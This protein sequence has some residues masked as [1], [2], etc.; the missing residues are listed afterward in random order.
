[1]RVKT[2]F[3]LV[4]I[5]LILLVAIVL[6]LTVKFDMGY[7]LIAVEVLSV[8]I[9]IL[10][11]LLYQRTIRPLQI[12][13][14][15]MDLVKSQDFN[16]RLQQVKQHDADKVVNLFNKILGELKDERLQLREKNQIL[17][18]LIESSPMGVIMLDLDNKISIINPA[19][20]QIM[21]C[22]DIISY[23][24]KSISELD[25]VMSDE[26]STMAAHSTKTVNLNDA[27]IYK[28]TNECFIVDG[29]THTFYL[30]E[31]MTDELLLAQQKTYN[32]V[33]R[34]IAH[35]VNNSMAGVVSTLDMV[36]SDIYNSENSEIAKLLSV[37]SDR[38]KNLSLFIT[39]FANVVK[40]PEPTLADLSLD[41]FITDNSRLFE[42]Q[43]AGFDIKFKFNLNSDNRKVK[44]DPILM[45]QVIINII[46]NG[47]E[48]IAS[49]GVIELSTT[50][51]PHQLIISNNGASI[52]SV[53]Q[54]NIFS[55]FF[56]TKP[57]GQG[58]GLLVVRDILSKHNF[59]FSLKTDSD[60]ITRFTIQF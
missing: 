17:D 46:K 9:I 47:I 56:T 20:I 49:D 48:A 35:E 59:K 15:G 37:S 29:Y 52:D 16:S 2:V 10:L 33:I 54:R 34:M 19:A 38:C 41:G 57:N 7:Y 13:I 58:I 31:K 40:I 55:P 30:I 11:V 25:C 50:L 14:K 39:K 22:E 3:F 6:E 5:V 45:E 42:S 24:G 4:V 44:I 53:T 23:I 1:M 27:N 28:C 36:E 8:V 43:V 26:L 60:G 12:I 18:I 51:Y 32:K 21:A